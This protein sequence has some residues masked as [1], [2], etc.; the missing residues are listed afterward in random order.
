MA[1]KTMT[2]NNGGNLPSEGWHVATVNKAEYGTYDGTRY[3]DLYFNGFPENLNARIY[4]A[5]N[6][7]TN[8][9]FRIAQLFRFANAGIVDVLEDPTGKKPVVQYDDDATH[10]IGKDL[11]VM[12]HKNEE[13]YLRVLRDTAPVETT[14]GE[15]ITFTA[16]DVSYWKKRAY[17][18]YENYVAKKSENNGFGSTDDSDVITASTDQ[19]KD[20]LTK[21]T[22]VAETVGEPPF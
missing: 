5:H 6:K 4:E 8:E 14:N 17:N 22:P 16:D 10:L 11:W 18:Y 15:K 9:E 13:G 2:L 21:N 1:I 7:T 3:I 19:I 12:I 20:L